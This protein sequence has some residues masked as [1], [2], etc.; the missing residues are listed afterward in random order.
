[1]TENTIVSPLALITSGNTL[2]QRDYG[3][4][5]VTN[6]AVR[7]SNP[8]V[9]GVIPIAVSANT[10]TAATNPK[11]ELSTTTNATSYSVLT[12]KNLANSQVQLQQR[13]ETNVI[14]CSCKYGQ[15]LTSTSGQNAVFRQAYRP[16]YWDGLKYSSPIPAASPTPS[17]PDT[18]SPAGEDPNAAVALPLPN[19]Q[20]SSGESPLCKYCCRDHHEYT[21]D[22]INPNPT[23]SS[24]I[25]I[26]DVVKFDP[27]R[28]STDGH[29]HYRWDTSVTPN[30]LTEVTNSTYPYRESCRMIRVDGL[31][32]T[33]AD[34]NAEQ[35]GF[36]AT[37][38]EAEANA[39]ANPVIAGG[40][41]LPSTNWIPNTSAETLY[42]G[43][44]KDYFDQKIAQGGT[45]VA[46]DLYNN[47]GLDNP[48]RLDINT[49]PPLWLHVRGLYLD[50]LE[51]AALKQI[52]TAKDHCPSGST[53]IEC[54][55]PY[56][57]FTSINL[58]ELML[59]APNNGLGVDSKV[60]VTNG[61][62][63][64]GVFS[65]AGTGSAQ[66]IRG[67]VTTSSSGGPRD[68]LLVKITKSN[69]GVAGFYPSIDPVLADGA[70]DATLVGHWSGDPATSPGGNT[71]VDHTDLQ[72][73]RVTSGNGD[74]FSVNLVGLAQTADAVT[75]ND[76]LVA[77]FASATDSNDCTTSYTDLSADPSPYGCQTDVNLGPTGAPMGV[78]VQNYIY[79]I[80]KTEANPCDATQS[81]VQH[82]Y[83]EY[84]QVSSATVN[85]TLLSPLSTTISNAG[86]VGESTLINIAP[87]PKNAV[88]Q[89][90]F[91]AST[92]AEGGATFT[93]DSSTNPPTFLGYNPPPCQ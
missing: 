68:D 90:N 67:K 54:V 41:T 66:P 42:Q 2:V 62:G 50:H 93:C 64:F 45:P 16:T 38:T 56:I 13:V 44:V 39:S 81:Q 91:T 12:Y 34:M 79:I 65:G 35:V 58:S 33:A 51:A 76:P 53:A 29:K 5:A 49:S 59:W 14:G 75:N 26:T 15:Q 23:S 30:A 73:F 22:E 4:G 80:N 78:A 60:Q 72:A 82:P 57:P 83:C 19:G 52:Q 17:T 27:F 24:D 21:N 71:I 1:L 3:S 74:P 43:F 28:S 85:G 25:Y 69:S 63:N 32:A 18:Y 40:S 10:D 47:E 70:G 6:P 31:W 7:T 46:D 8:A 11:P 9:P 37:R 20:T 88:V 87:L 36:V 89:I 92:P 61:S 48:T 77:W 86:K 84:S 55:L